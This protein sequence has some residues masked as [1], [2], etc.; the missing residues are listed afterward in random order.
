MIPFNTDVSLFSNVNAKKPITIK[1]SELLDGNRWKQQV[2]YVRDATTKEERRQRKLSLPAV[3]VSGVFSGR[4]ASNLVRH[5]RLLCLD[6]D[7]QD[8]PH[9]SNFTELKYQLGKI[10]QIAY[11][12]A[13]VSGI[14][15][16]LF[17]LVPIAHPEQHE[18]QFKAIQRDLEQLFSIRIDK[19]CKDVSRLRFVSYDLEPYWNWQAEPYT[20]L[21]DPPK[22]KPRLQRVTSSQVAP[23]DRTQE[24]VEA[25]I[26]ILCA[27]C[28]DITRD[29]TD[30]INIAA[31]LY[32]QFGEG[33]RQYFHEVSQFHSDYSIEKTD[34]KYS[35]CQNMKPGIGTFFNVC[36][37]YGVTY[38][39]D[40][41]LI[42]QLHIS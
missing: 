11:A 17:C 29:Y 35:Q 31:A 10:N 36:K 21:Y 22:P 7:R 14:E 2:D 32:N 42:N 34:K 30:W 8:N 9:I 4:G 37:R 15:H 28:I 38:V 39:K 23:V 18:K 12:G 27:S 20:K 16:G 25:C 3:T 6:V 24:R 1:L 19:A 41:Q 13:S 33:G 40:Q 26:S 5:S